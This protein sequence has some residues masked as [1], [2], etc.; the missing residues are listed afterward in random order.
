MRTTMGILSFIKL[1]NDMLC[2]MQW[3]SLLALG[4]LNKIVIQYPTYLCISGIQRSKLTLQN[5]SLCGC[6]FLKG[7]RTFSSSKDHK[8]Y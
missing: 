7:I 4:K 3:L 2:G 1:C 6:N 8:N 5:L